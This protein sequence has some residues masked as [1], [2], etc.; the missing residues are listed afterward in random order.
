M[1]VVLSTC[2]PVAQL[3]LWCNVSERPPPSHLVL[4]PQLAKLNINVGGDA[5]ALLSGHPSVVPFVKNYKHC[6]VS[7]EVWTGGRGGALGGAWVCGVGVWCGSCSPYTDQH[8]HQ[9]ISSSCH[10][11]LSCGVIIMS[12]GTTWCHHHGMRYHVVSSS[13]CGIMVELEG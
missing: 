9:K 1:H 8:R 7:V 6:D 10:V 5:S 13:W 2:A 4:V 3:K 11:V 12:C